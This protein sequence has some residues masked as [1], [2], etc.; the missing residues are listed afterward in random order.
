MAEITL[1][2]PASPELVRTA[3]LVAT[4]AA[5][6]WGMDDEV[7]EDVRL[8]VGEA[9]GRAVVR[10]QD[11]NVEEPVRLTILDGPERF[12]VRL[13]DSSDQTIEDADEGLSIEMIKS[14]APQVQAGASPAADGFVISM[15]WDAAVRVNA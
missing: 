3:R 5:R 14:L 10:H 12:E 13:R 11:Q 15:S 8:A 6:R 2:I 9:A 7:V 4:T 1:D